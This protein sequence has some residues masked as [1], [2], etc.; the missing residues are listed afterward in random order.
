MNRSRSRRS[1]RLVAGLAA[2]LAMVTSASAT[3]VPGAAATFPGANGRIAFTSDRTGN[4]DVFTTTATGAAASNLSRALSSDRD[5]AWSAD[6]RRVAYTR[7]VAGN[8]DIY[9]TT[10]STGR[11]TRITTSPAVDVSAAW[12]PDGRRLVFVSNR[13]GSASGSLDV[14]LV[15]AVREGRT[16]RPVR[17]TNTV[18]DE[19]N[20][21][22]SPNGRQIAFDLGLITWDVY[23]MRANGAG[24]R[25]VTDSA[26]GV[27]RL[28]FDPSW[29]PDGRHIAFDNGDDIFRIAAT[30]N[31]GLD[32]VNCTNLTAANPDTAETDPAWSPDGTQIAFVTSRDRLPDGSANHEIYRMSATDGSGQVNLTRHPAQDEGPAWGPRPVGR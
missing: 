4:G 20:P 14:Y 23:V 2:T 5:G 1:G 12:S 27:G 32:C 24:R 10:V 22:W 30:A 31:G 26:F 15:R 19:N 21:E 11:T 16:N 25:A 8:I 29:S 9:V 17:I 6:G 7:T 18:G 28:Y 3:S 13:P